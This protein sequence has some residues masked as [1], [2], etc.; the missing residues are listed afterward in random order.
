MKRVTGLGGS[1]SQWGV[2]EADVLAAL[3]ALEER[4]TG[5]AASGATHGATTSERVYDLCDGRALVDHLLERLAS[6]QR[7]HTGSSFR[8]GERNGRREEEC[9]AHL[10]TPW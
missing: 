6:R 8:A 10:D 2:Q 5:A 1:W 7:P 3:R 4:T 9:A